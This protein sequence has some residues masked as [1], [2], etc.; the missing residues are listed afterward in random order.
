MYGMRAVCNSVCHNAC[1]IVR[2]LSVPVH[3][4]QCKCGSLF[5]VSVPCTLFPGYRP[6][7]WRQPEEE[8]EEEE[9]IQGLTPRRRRGDEMHQEVAHLFRIQNT[10]S[11]R[12]GL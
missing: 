1:V 8:V 10:R 5:M 4:P 11:G 9:R 12:G 3:S 2:I 6:L 7:A